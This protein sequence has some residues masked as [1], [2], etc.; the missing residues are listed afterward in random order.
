MDYTNQ[1]ALDAIAKK[2]N[3]EMR[4]VD[5]TNLVLLTEIGDK[6]AKKAKLF[7]FSKI[8]MM[9]R[10]GVLNGVLVER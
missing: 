4:P 9:H 3:A 2:C 10:I 8:Q 7:G 1:N 5:K 6:W